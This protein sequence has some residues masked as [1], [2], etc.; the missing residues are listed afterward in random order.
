MTAKESGGTI[1]RSLLKI[2]TGEFDIESIHTLALKNLDISDLGCI[3]ECLGL[4]RLDLSYNDITK[5]HKLAGLSALQNLNLSA[6]RFSSLDGLQ[7][8]ENLHSLNI[9]G[10]LIGSVDSLQCLTGLQNLRELRLKDDSIQL[11]N[12]ACLHPSYT[13]DIIEMF[14]SLL[15]LDGQRVRGQGSELFYICQEM[16]KE[17]KSFGEVKDIDIPLV[18]VQHQLTDCWKLP[19]VVTNTTHNKAEEQLKDLLASCQ[20]LSQKAADK[21]KEFEKQASQ[22]Q[23]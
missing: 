11:S 13:A 4:E 15:L 18:K 14:P 5:L 3:G 8:L 1:T 23:N 6:N 21:L 12:P 2:T 10:N 22:Q 9:A 19:S 16:D 20:R 17:L 7:S